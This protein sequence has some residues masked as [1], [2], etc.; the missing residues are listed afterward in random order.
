MEDKRVIHITSVGDC[1]KKFQFE[2]QGAP[3]SRPHAL[4]IKGTINHS[5]MEQ[6]LRFGDIKY[7]DKDSILGKKTEGVDDNLFKTCYAQCETLIPN[8][9]GWITNNNLVNFDASPEMER[10]LTLR[11][12]NFLITGQIDYY[13][14]EKI[15]DFKSGRRLLQ[16]HKMQLAGYHWLLEQI[17]GN[18]DREC[19]IILFGKDS[20]QERLIEKKE[21]AT[22]KSRFKDMLDS[23]IQYRAKL[24]N[25]EKVH[26]K[27]TS[28]LIK[29]S[30]CD[31]RGICT[32][33]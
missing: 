29:C 14:N 17:E 25:G 24:L 19:Y 2:L 20:P 1:P 22:L 12:K 5:L 8:L 27:P 30:F 3:K 7:R 13:D 15:I 28:E 4:G 33:I 32:G 23:E 18:H 16:S 21:I 10:R 26:C 31:Y 11:Y 6:M 9:K